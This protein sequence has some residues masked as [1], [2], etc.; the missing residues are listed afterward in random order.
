VR[1]ESRTFDSSGRRR[2]IPLVSGRETF[3][4]RVE[5]AVLESMW[6]S[7]LLGG[8]RRTRVMPDTCRA[9]KFPPARLNAADSRDA[10]PGHKAG[11]TRLFG[12]SRRGLLE[13]VLPCEESD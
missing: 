13:G 2:G 12:D 11:W 10:R 8:L 4:R 5:P 3:P 1:P 6:L 7:P 9:T